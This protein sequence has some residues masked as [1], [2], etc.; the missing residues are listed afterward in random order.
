MISPAEPRRPSD[1]SEAGHG[2]RQSLPSLPS[3]SEVF[4]EKKALGYAPPPSSAPLPSAQS[5]P[6]PF[7][8]APPPRPFTDLASP[9]KN[10]SPRT[11][12]P[13]SS[14]FSRP[15]SLPAFADSNLPSL[16]GRPV[17]PPL[18]TFPGHHT[19]PPVKY[20]QVEAEQRHAEAQNHRPPPPHPLPGLYSETGRL[21]PG[22]LPLSAYPISPRHSAGPGL[23]SPFETRGS[24]HG[25]GEEGEYS[26]HR[27]A[28]Y[29]AALDKHFQAN[30]Y[31]D[32]LQDVG[33]GTWAARKTSEGWLTDSMMQIMRSCRTGYHFAEAYVAAAQEQQGTQPLPSRMPT[34]NE[35]SVLLNSLIFALKKL[36]DVRD[37]VQQNRIQNERARENGGRNA[38]DEDVSMYGDGIKPAYS[39]HE[40]K[41]RRG[42]SFLSLPVR[43]QP[44]AR[45]HAHA[46]IANIPPSARLL[47]GGATA[48][49]G[50]TRRNG[51]AAPTAQ[52]RSATRVAFTTP[53]SSAS[54]SWTRDQ[55]G[56][57]PRM[58]GSELLWIADARLSRPPDRC[59]QGQPK[60][61]R[62]SRQEPV[63]PLIHD[64]YFMFGVPEV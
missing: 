15:D 18:N 13:V 25:Y 14:S 4:A 58:S 45:A 39:M 52:G 55:S 23:P 7:T 9:D 11:L 32:A 42:V 22:Q 40:V 34:E 27:L 59:R 31:Q 46:Q 16:A 19:S 30:G 3:I 10:P 41:K 38:D 48:A 21:P 47:P 44:R 63:L 5:L 54:G 6:S 53:N 57:N 12:H 64:W 17:P 35:V 20:E 61:I 62:F 29:K 50:S 1:D 24:A 49:T 33:F 43:A 37:M 28:D 26:P 56:R 36:E 60:I 51:G 8:S 2:H